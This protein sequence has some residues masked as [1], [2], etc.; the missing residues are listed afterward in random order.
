MLRT[1]PNQGRPQR[2]MII[3]ANA[4]SAPTM[5][6]EP[7]IAPRCCLAWST[8]GRTRARPGLAIANANTAF[9]K[10]L[11]IVIA[12]ITRQIGIRIGPRI[13]WSVVHAAR[14]S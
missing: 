11:A 8:P 5:A 4:S 6:P 13:T 10:K 3:V 1:I 9:R 12:M 7:R 2:V 14:A